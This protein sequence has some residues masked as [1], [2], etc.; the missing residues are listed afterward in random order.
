MKTRQQMRDKFEAS[1]LDYSKINKESI[2]KLCSIL[3]EELK[4]FNNNGFTMKIRAGRIADFEYNLNGSLSHAYISVQG[5]TGEGY[6][7]FN[8]RQGIAFERLNRSKETFIGFC[9]WADDTN[10]KPFL[11]AFD[12]WLITSCS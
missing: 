4:K 3:D 12:K 8:R 6:Q 10:V 5:I 1:N 7:H 11:N 9:G 2:K